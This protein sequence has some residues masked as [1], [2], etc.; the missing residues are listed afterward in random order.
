M[1]VQ[2]SQDQLRQYFASLIRFDY[3]G[4]VQIIEIHMMR[5]RRS[6]LQILVLKIGIKG[7]FGRDYSEIYEYAN[8]IMDN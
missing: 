5:K 8:R 1:L 2:V 3:G 4:Q 6:G 7:F